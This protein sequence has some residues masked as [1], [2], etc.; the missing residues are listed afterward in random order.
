[1]RKK[2][3]WQLV[4]KEFLFKKK[5]KTIIYVFQELRATHT[6]SVPFCDRDVHQLLLINLAQGFSK[7][8]VNLP[9]NR[10]HMYRQT[11]LYESIDRTS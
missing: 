9:G 2:S 5:W 6:N 11:T 8:T 10:G 7:M 4:L 1:M 3:L